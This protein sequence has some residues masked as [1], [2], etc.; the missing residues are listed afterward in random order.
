MHAD[1]NVTAVFEQCPQTPILFGNTGLESIMRAIAN[2][3]TGDVFPSD[4]LLIAALHLEYSKITNLIG[5]ERIPWPYRLRLFGNPDLEDLGPAHL[6]TG[7]T[8]FDIT[9][10]QKTSDLGPLSGMPNLEEINV[11]SNLL[12]AID[13]LH[14]LPN[15]RRF[16]AWENRIS[17]IGPLGAIPTIQEI[18]MAN[19]RVTDIT[20]LAQLSELEWLDLADNFDPTS[21]PPTYITDIS[22]LAGLTRLTRLDLSAGKVTDISAL[23]NLTNLIWVNLNTNKITD[24]SPLVNNSGFGTG[25]FLFVLDNPLTPD[26]CGQI[27]ALVARGVMV[28]QNAGCSK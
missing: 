15:L 4:F 22:P 26:A 3:P 23:E 1:V 2:K 12:T 9:D 6:M 13:D 17:D 8:I 20:A 11:G 24:L 27:D 28:F 18:H 25:D 14:D 10:N 19:N 21:N 7:L 5:L 16:S